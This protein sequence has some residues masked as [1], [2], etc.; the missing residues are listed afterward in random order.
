VDGPRLAREN[1]ACRTEVAK[2]TDLISLGEFLSLSA[3]NWRRLFPSSANN[4]QN[5]GA[6]G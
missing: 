5:S 6:D 2:S 3:V 1:A 4:K